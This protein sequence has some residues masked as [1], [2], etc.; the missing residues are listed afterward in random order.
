MFK[1]V[2]WSWASVHS[3]HTWL[4]FNWNSSW[5]WN[6]LFRSAKSD[7]DWLFCPVERPKQKLIIYACHFQHSNSACDLRKFLRGQP[8][9]YSSIYQH[10]P[11]AGSGSK[12]SD[13]TSTICCRTCGRV[14][15]ISLLLQTSAWRTEQSRHQPAAADIGLQNSHNQSQTSVLL[16]EPGVITIDHYWPMTY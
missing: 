6:S 10:P 14:R 7:C 5:S 2:S 11:V 16:L 4:F 1:F 8:L 9:T 15:P 13:I 3:R 12:R